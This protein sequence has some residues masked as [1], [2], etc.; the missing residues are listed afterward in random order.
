MQFN[1]TA[2]TPFYPIE[3]GWTWP[4]V[5]DLS[6]SGYLYIY[7]EAARPP[8]AENG[9]GE[10]FMV[11]TMK[12]CLDL[13]SRMSAPHIYLMHWQGDGLPPLFRRV[14][15]LSVDMSDEWTGQA[16]LDLEPQPGQ[17]THYY[18]NCTPETV[19]A[20][21][22]VQILPRVVAGPPPH[23]ERKRVKAALKSGS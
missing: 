10:R 20:G 14:L 3:K 4:I 19:D 23:I 12:W 13:L 21:M 8:T 1:P 15:R 16:L 22:M 18:W 7:D 9:Y 6:R 11:G 5:R 17:S 2:K